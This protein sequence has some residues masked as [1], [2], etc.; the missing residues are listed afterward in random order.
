[1]GKAEA[2]L[3][4]NTSTLNIDEIAASTSRAADGRRQSLFQ[5]GQC[6][7]AVGD[8]PRQTIETG[9]LA[10]SMALGS[11][12]EK[13]A[14]S[15]ATAG[16]SVGNRMFGL[17]CVKRPRRRGGAKVQD[18]DAALYEW[19]WRWA[20]RSRTWR[21]STWATSPQRGWHHIPKG[22]RP[23][24]AD[25]RLVEAGRHGQKTNAGWY[26]YAKGAAHRK[27]IPKQNA[28]LPRPR[29]RGRSSSAPSQEN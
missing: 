25:N 12:W 1:V 17:T 16:A 29:K 19:A 27:P 22:M 24:L 9:V 6:D 23:H 14:C 26:R 11:D 20:A 3:A 13:S 8:R 5:S 2:I 21:V 4:S 18:V 7:E 10:T 28:S 15:S